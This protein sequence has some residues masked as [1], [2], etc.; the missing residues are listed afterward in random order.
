MG[1]IMGIEPIPRHSQ[2]RMLKPL[3]HTRHYHSLFNFQRSH[4]LTKLLNLSNKKTL[5]PFGGEESYE[6]L[7]YGTCSVHNPPPED[8]FGDLNNMFWAMCNSHFHN[9]FYT[10]T[11]TKIP[12]FII[13]KIYYT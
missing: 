5:L 7:E 12:S 9:S 11:I 13:H 8:W 10:Q 3:H 6:L 1:R 4:K 2:C